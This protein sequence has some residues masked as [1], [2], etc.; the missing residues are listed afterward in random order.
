MRHPLH[1]GFSLLELLVVISV[2]SVVTTIGVSAFV[3]I[4]TAWRQTTE[5]VELESTADMI[6]EDYLAQDIGRML[7]PRLSGAPMSG[8]QGEA[9]AFFRIRVEDD[10]MIIPVE[11]PNE[12]GGLDRHSVRYHVDRERELPTLI[13]TIGPLGADMSSGLELELATGV[14]GLRFEYFDGTAW[15]PQWDKPELPLSVRAHVAL[16]DVYQ[17]HQ[18]ISRKATFPIHVR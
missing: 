18:Q 15:Q 3:S 1:R 10:S 9:E 17:Q 12:S 11:V 14:F 7:S 16:M 2:L 13:R 8:K 5:L 4:T 6:L